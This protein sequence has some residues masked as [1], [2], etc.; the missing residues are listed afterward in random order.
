MLAVSHSCCPVLSYR[1]PTVVCLH[2]YSHIRCPIKYPTPPTISSKEDLG[3]CDRSA[4]NTCTLHGGDSTHRYLVSSSL[5]S[6]RPGLLLLITLDPTSTRSCRIFRDCTR[7]QKVCGFEICCERK[8][9][10]PGATRLR[11]PSFLG[12][13]AKGYLTTAP[14]THQGISHEKESL[15][16]NSRPKPQPQQWEPTSAAKR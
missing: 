4:G 2:M 14:R 5:P 12:Q 3:R 13:T 8:T 11:S 16:A 6:S 7:T 9:R 15:D 10:M 1:C